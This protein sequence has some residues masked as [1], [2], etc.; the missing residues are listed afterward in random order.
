M[1]VSIGAWAFL[2]YTQTSGKVVKVR[3]FGSRHSYLEFHFS[4]IWLCTYL[5]NKNN[6]ILNNIIL[7]FSILCISDFYKFFS[8]SCFTFIFIPQSFILITCLYVWVYGV[9]MCGM[10]VGV[11]IYSCLCQRKTISSQH[12]PVSTLQCWSFRNQVCAAMSSSYMGISTQVIF[13]W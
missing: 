9:C 3:Y 4:F 2:L 8:P 12:S 10:C 11:H 1:F 13:L 6:N 7:L 5:Q